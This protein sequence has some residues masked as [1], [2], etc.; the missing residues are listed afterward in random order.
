MLKFAI[1]RALIS[2]PVLMMVVLMIFFMLN[3][4][5]GDPI[6]VMMKEHIKPAVI[7]NLRQKMNLDDPFFIKYVKY[8]GGMFQGD[9]GISYKLSRPVALQLSLLPS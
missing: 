8:I 2:V 1:K 3:V 6:T 9:L 4:I 5:P 7:E